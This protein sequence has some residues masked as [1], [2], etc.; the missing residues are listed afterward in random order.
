[1]LIATPSAATQ[2]PADV[3]IRPGDALPDPARFGND[4]RNSPAARFVRVYTNDVFA[5]QGATAVSYGSRVP[6]EVRLRFLTYDLAKLADGVLKDTVLG[7]RLVYVDPQ[8]SPYDMSLP[9]SDW[10]RYPTNFARNV[11]AMPDVSKYRWNGNTIIFET[12][13]TEARVRL[14]QLVE[15]SLDGSLLAYWKGECFGPGC[16]PDPA[17]PTGEI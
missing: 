3:V 5:L 17:P 13:S 12:T 7:A 15:R 11:A 6:D 8:G 2:S 1:M 9:A 10:V 16:K 14:Q 4:L